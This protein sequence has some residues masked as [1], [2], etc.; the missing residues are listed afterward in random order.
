MKP[1][2][3]KKELKGANA[4]EFCRDVLFSPNS[5]LFD[6][7]EDESLSGTY[8]DFRSA[9]SVATGVPEGEIRLVGSS[10]F[11][12]S[13]SPRPEKLFRE[14]DDSS[15]LDVVIVSEELFSEIWGEFL[16]AYYGG[17][18]WIKNRHGGDVFRKFIYLLGSERYKTDY[19]RDTARKLDGMK[20]QVLLRTGLT[21]DL[22]YRIYDS[23]NSAVDYHAH[24][25]MKLQKVIED[26]AE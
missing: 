8:N 16:N 4:D 17:Y 14:F 5:W 24:G 22:K 1:D 15:D 9:I 13:M 25:V 6:E 18:G 19:L 26:A 12:I 23:W 3:L 11:G 7:A 20:R 21:R 2:E 10:R